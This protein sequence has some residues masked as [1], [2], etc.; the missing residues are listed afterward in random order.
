MMIFSFTLS[1]RTSSPQSSLIGVSVLFSLAGISWR[2]VVNFRLFGIC[3]RLTLSSWSTLL[4][5]MNFLMEVH[6]V[7]KPGLHMIVFIGVVNHSCRFRYKAFICISW[8]NMRS[9]RPVWRCQARHPCSSLMTV[10]VRVRSV[11]HPWLL[12]S[13]GR[14]TI[15]H[16][17][18]AILFAANNTILSVVNVLIFV[19]R[20]RS[21]QGPWSVVTLFI[22]LLLDWFNMVKMVSMRLIALGVYS[23]V[24]V[25]RVGVSMVVTTFVAIYL[26]LSRGTSVRHG[27]IIG[28]RASIP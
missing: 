20:D 17:D 4:L 13:F 12:V 22:D 1:R 24:R 15:A 11:L 28:A 26:C 9:L 27:N 6:L 10:P 25:L 5:F 2:L 8:M 23:S 16:D 21:V 14:W 19:L 18:S 3:R 7:L